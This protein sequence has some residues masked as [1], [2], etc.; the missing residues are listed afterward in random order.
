MFTKHRR[1]SSGQ[2]QLDHCVVGLM[3]PSLSRSAAEPIARSPNSYQGPEP[4][5]C[6]TGRV[7]SSRRGL[8]MTYIGIDVSKATLDVAVHEGPLTQVAND[9]AGIA[10]VVAQL[11]ARSCTLIV[12][13]ATGVYHHSVTAALVAAALPVAVVNPRQVRDFARST[14]Q[15]AKTD[16]LD[17]QLLARFAAVV[18]PTPR[19]VPDD[20]MLELVALVDRRRQLLDMLTAERNRL[21]IARRAVKPSVTRH[22]KFLEQ[23]IARAEDDLDQWMQQSPA[24]RAQEDLLRSVPGIGP[25]TAQLLI[26][27]LPELGQ[28]SR[29]EIAALVGV[30]PMARESGRCTGGRAPVRAMLYMATLTATRCNPVIRACYQRLRA[31]NK[32]PKLA[33]IACLRRLLTI[34]NAMVK[35]QQRW[36]TNVL[37]TA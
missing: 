35:T 21:A 37:T 16:R 31:A 17:A 10:T 13:E 27:T 2:Q 8:V 33:L 23:A 9:A 7:R 14:G 32:P 28:L 24:W 5:S 30:A 1:I 3:S 12:L 15:L 4:A 26:A 29:R 34:L 6:K 36:H 22:I 19:P 11:R 25:H 20:A 18:R